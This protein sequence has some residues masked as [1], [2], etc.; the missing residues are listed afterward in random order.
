MR[1]W[2]RLAKI[3]FWGLV[4]I[5]LITA[6]AA[7]FAYALVTDSETAARMIKGQAARFLP[8]S[9]VEIGRVNIGILKGEVTVSHF[10]VL[11]RIDD[12]SF[13]TARVP[14]LSVR[15]DPRQVLHGRFAPR[16]VV[17]SQPTLRLCRRS[18][19]TWNIQSLIADPWPGPRIKNPPPIV[20]RNGT[21]ELV[22]D[23]DAEGGA[24]GLP[25]PALRLA[26]VRDFDRDNEVVRTRDSTPRPRGDA[27]IV[28]APPVV[29]QGIATQTARE[30]TLTEIPGPAGSLPNQGVAILRDVS[31]RIEGVE[32]GQLRFEGSAHGD[33]FEKLT[34]EGSIDPI[35]GDTVLRGELTGLT[36]SENLRRRLP[37]EIRSQFES[38]GLNRGEIDIELRRLAIHLGAPRDRRFE[39]DVLA[40]LHGGVWE[41][42]SLPFPVNDLSAL[43]AISNGLVSIKHA[44]GSNGN[45]ILRAVGSLAMGQ[46]A[47]CPFD[48]R[49]DLLQ[50]E[51]DKRL[52][53]RTPSQFAE[54]WDVFKPRGLLDA[55]IHL[56]REQ[57]NGP[58]SVGATVLCRDVAAV[59]RHFPYPV[60]HMGG[61][62]TLENQRLSVDL[63]GLIGERP[64]LLK[65]TIDN[66]GPD[67]LVRLD[68]QADS[69]PIDAAFLAALPLD[70]RKVVDQ[71]RPAGSVKAK[72][73]ILRK[74]MTGPRAKPEG[75]LV[76]DADLDLNPRCEITWAGL[77]YPIR[78]LTG[79]LELHPDLWEFK[80]MRGGNGQAIIKGNGRVEKLVGPNHPNGEPPLKID[81]QIE[82]QNLPF[83]DDLRK[84]L[85][86][87]WQKTWSIINPTGASDVEASI[88]VEPDRPD[89]NHILIVPLRD[90]SV[91]LVIHRTPQ[92][93]FDPGG[94]FELRMENVHGRFDFDNGKVVMNDVNFLFHGA[95]VQFASGDVMVEDS[96]RFAL[97]VSELWVK[98]IRFDSSL[99]AIMP[100]LMA[101]FAL[102][103]DDGRPFTARGNLQI[104][105]SGED[106]E[107]AW[108]RWDN[109]RVVFIDNTLKAG[110]PLEHI[111]GQLEDVRGWS[112]GQTMEI[113]G[114]VKLDS[115]TLMGQQI[116]AVESP[117]HLKRG[118][119][120]LDSLRG[121]LLRGDLE[122]SGTISLDTTPKYSASLRLAGAQLEEY[123]RTL[124]GRQSYRGA[125]GAAIDLSG[126]G[127]NVR[128]I[129]GKGEAHITQGDLG[130]LP[131]ALRFINF[132]N[133]NL[134]LLDSPRTS[135]KTFFDSADVAFR[136]D[137]GTAILDPIKLTGSAF[138]LQG[139]GN[140]DPL[141]N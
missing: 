139:S 119:A 84:A 42:P 123:A 93:G 141:G 106:G 31:L 53:E 21:I 10:H 92:P 128:S 76:I 69:V 39:Y 36:L 63:H 1:L 85:Q 86:P 16:E 108:C 75:H 30:S 34:L 15:L 12:Q 72:V 35:T 50:L 81:L 113:Q 82:A 102:R 133:S 105:W 104:G 41:C 27:A 2:R 124:P 25:V 46:A 117:F 116:T 64:A 56:A 111:Q 33:L 80:N 120:Q 68:I 83:N 57:E 110:I 73:R 59:Y 115:I 70:V 107:P 40:R 94:T 14:W 112:N 4:L 77:P 118:S 103:L 99:R 66:P 5:V 87:A 9:I 44:E 114:I 49:L 28:E 18:D 135:G 127:N 29:R 122:G 11:Q 71:F 45:T 13:L 129:Q 136:I 74:P 62:L 98:E 7:W 17:V 132:L 61:S 91:R 125:L 6:G 109:T 38:L 54:L 52:Q 24:A 37:P 43:V 130:E 78:N 101:Q 134:S 65:G 20:I 97:V 90:S 79:R 138:S 96:G 55:Y 88:H 22:G 137:H 140:R 100:P 32:G 47:T 3:L 58:V 51:M 48:L 67:A 131:V 89:I 8:R 19:G 121:K 95:P 26:R 23:V 60:E 126:L